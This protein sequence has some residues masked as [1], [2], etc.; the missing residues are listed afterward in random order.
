[1]HCQTNVLFTHNVRYETHVQQW[2]TKRADNYVFF[3][4]KL[5]VTYHPII[6]FFY[7]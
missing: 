4:V 6:R 5:N 2:T 7:K 3:I 1:M